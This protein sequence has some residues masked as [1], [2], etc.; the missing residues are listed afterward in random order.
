[1]QASL[2]AKDLACR[3]GDRVLFTGLDLSLA[4]GG[5]VHV[6]GPNGIGKSSLIRLLAGLSHPFAGE[7]TRHGAVGLVDERPAL[8]PDL[9]LGAALAFW[10]RVDG[11]VTGTR[12]AEAMEIA[13]LSDVPVRYLSTGQRKRAA[14]ARLLDQSAHVWLLDEPLNGLDGAARELIEALVSKHR[15]NGGVCVVASHQPMELPGC[16]TLELTR[17]AESPSLKGGARGGC[18]APPQPPSTPT[19]PPPQG[20]G[21]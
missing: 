7:V 14:F 4:S 18:T 3:R 20:G 13:E 5:A 9:P 1:M 16:E 11:C 6:T 17:Y 10:R 19:R 21:A 2:A 15:E 8:D 12:S